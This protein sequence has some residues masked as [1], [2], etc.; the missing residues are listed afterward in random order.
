MAACSTLIRG[1]LTADILQGDGR[2]TPAAG[3]PQ[4]AVISP[5]LANIYLDPLD[6][7]MAE[8]GYRNG[9]LCGRLRDPSE[10]PRRGRSRS[11]ARS[12]RGWRR[13]ASRCTLAK[14]HDRR[15]PEEGARVRVPRLSVR[16]GRRRVRK[17]SLT[18]C[19]ATFARRRDGPEA[20]ASARRRRP[21]P[22]APR[23]VRLLQACP[24]QHLRGARPVVRR[25]LRAMLRKQERR[26]GVGHCRADH[27][28]WPNAFF[29]DAGLFALH[30]AWQTARQSR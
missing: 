1:W 27:Q 26:P 16:A 9:A 8:L 24:S 5:L 2:W 4:G 19:K 29:A 18:S 10:R 17:K 30:T 3:T 15:L 13:T 14:T 20:T 23:L 21:Q 6:R 28:R 12:A 25:R 7:L 11:G 22:D